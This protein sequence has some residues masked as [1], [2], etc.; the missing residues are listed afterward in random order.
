MVMV[1]TRGRRPTQ[2]RIWSSQER[3]IARKNRKIVRL[4]RQRN[5]A[6]EET[7]KANKMLLQSEENKLKLKQRHEQEMAEFRRLAQK[8]K[9]DAVAREARKHHKAMERLVADNKLL[10]EQRHPAFINRPAGPDPEVKMLTAEE[11][12]KLAWMKLD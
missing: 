9:E 8:E 12:E 7:E 6:R 1:T 3:R 4:K 10:V 5:R 2:A 11:A